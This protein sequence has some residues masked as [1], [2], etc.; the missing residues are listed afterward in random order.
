MRNCN[1]IEDFLIKSQF[2]F[3][4]KGHFVTFAPYPYSLH[5]YPLHKTTFDNFKKR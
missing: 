2:T 1:F 4:L 3:N 5:R